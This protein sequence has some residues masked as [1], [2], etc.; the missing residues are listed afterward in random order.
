LEKGDDEFVG[1]C[2]MEKGDVG[3]KRWMDFFLLFSLFEAFLFVMVL[4][5]V[6]GRSFEWE[7]LLEFPKIILKLEVL[8]IF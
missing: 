8:L 6:F 4:A 2:E 7:L 1:N 5:V 3:V